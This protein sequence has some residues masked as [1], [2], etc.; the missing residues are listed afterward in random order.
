MF[1]ISV[2]C[3]DQIGHILRYKGFF[4][5]IYGK[6]HSFK[7]LQQITLER[8]ERKCKE[9]AERNLF[10]QSNYWPST[11]KSKHGQ[12]YKYLLLA[13]RWRDCQ[14][15]RIFSNFY[16]VGFQALSAA[17]C[18]KVLARVNSRPTFETSWNLIYHTAPPI[19]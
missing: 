6:I 4:W 2:D 15:F 14:R 10:M 3:K 13:F 16:T 11:G 9:H 8:W 12:Y 18:S 5:Y 7:S 19:K 17:K 1:E